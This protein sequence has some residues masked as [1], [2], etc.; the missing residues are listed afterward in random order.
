M[1]PLQVSCW[2]GKF[3]RRTPEWY[4]FNYYLYTIEQ[5]ALR[6]WVW[7]SYDANN[8]SQSWGRRSWDWP[9]SSHVTEYS[10]TTKPDS[11]VLI[12]IMTW[13]FSFHPMNVSVVINIRRWGWAWKS[14]YIAHRNV[15]V[16]TYPCHNIEAGLANRVA[17]DTRSAMMMPSNEHIF[18]VTGPLCGEFTGHLLNPP[19]KGQ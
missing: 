5:W 8:S 15:D 12:T 13:H 11:A 3:L 1:T 19:H 16:V 14:N 17:E 4:S 9:Y 2:I 10:V 7:C 6:T 18:R